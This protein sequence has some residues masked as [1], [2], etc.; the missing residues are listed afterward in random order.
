[1]KRILKDI[2]GLNTTDGYN[3]D[4]I[5]DFELKFGNI[6]KA[7]KEFYKICG[8]CREINF[9][10]DEWITPQSYEKYEW[11]NMDKNLVL[12]NEN[13]GVWEVQIL[14]EDLNKD[15]PP[16]YLKYNE[17]EEFFLCNEKTS[18]FIKNMLVFEGI[19]QFEYSSEA[20][21]WITDNEFEYIKN[22]LYKY[23]YIPNKLFSENGLH[24]FYMTAD[25]AIAIMND[26]GEYQMFYGAA[27]RKS[28]DKIDELLKDIG[29][30]V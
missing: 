8:K 2:Y 16:V 20:F 7:V 28:Y 3:E 19:F 23:P 10:Q 11:L 18:E 17:C 15:D 24:L 9:I 6:P 29:K 25:S 5:A 22:N 26:T 14:R 13:Q 1:M 4:E 12:M 30:E 27:S 21:Y